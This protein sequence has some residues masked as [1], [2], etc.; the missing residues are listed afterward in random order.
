[1]TGFEHPRSNFG[2]YPDIAD[3][4]PWMWFALEGLA[5]R[6]G[7]ETHEI[8]LRDT[9]TL[10]VGAVHGAMSRVPALAERYTRD[11]E[12]RR[13]GKLAGLY[14]RHAFRNVVSRVAE[15][16]YDPPM[17]W[18]LTQEHPILRADDEELERLGVSDVDIVVPDTEPKRSSIHTVQRLHR[19]TSYVWNQDAYEQ[20]QDM[21]LRSELIRPA[22]IEGVTG[23]P[24]LPDNG[25]SVL[26]KTSGS[27]MKQAWISRLVQALSEATVAVD[28]LAS[29]EDS[30][31][32]SLYTP[33]QHYFLFGDKP[34]SNKRA[35]I[36]QFCQSICLN[37]SIIIGFPT[38]LVAV[39][40]EARLKGAPTLLL[41]CPPRGEHEAQNL[42]YAQ[43]HGLLLGEIDFTGNHE[44]S[45]KNIQRVRIDDLACVIVEAHANRTEVPPLSPDMVGAVTYFQH[46]SV[47][48]TSTAA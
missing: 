28:K 22:L 30:F 29:V 40:A 44:P 12:S 16:A 20:L 42:K 4:N 39:V 7:I 47:Q 15:V 1:M 46:S 32:W 14:S 38:E 9:S 23:V 10:L 19:A 36:T 35:R 8:A 21:G 34:L 18:I 24:I 11:S 6:R 37:T 25:A 43:K 41:A 33:S 13:N 31:D 48:S 17:R 26:A 5:T 3:G 45:A 27:G 2:I